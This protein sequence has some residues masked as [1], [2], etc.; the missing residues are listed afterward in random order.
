M[1][2]LNNS[3][4]CTL[5]DD[6]SEKLGKKIRDNELKRIP[7]LLIVGEKEVENNTVSI[8]KQG[9]GDKGN[10]TIDEFVSFIK[11]EIN[12]KSSHFDS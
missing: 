6:R 10:M 7:Y 2:I 11:E 9:D 5:I 8:R 4:I 3:D 12:I 1:Q